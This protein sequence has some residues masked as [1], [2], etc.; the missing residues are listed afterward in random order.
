MA[1]KVYFDTEQLISEIRS[2]DPEL[3]EKV[4]IVANSEGTLTH[5]YVRY[6]DRTS[7]NLY[8]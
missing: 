3:F 5:V 8:I 1:C 2:I 7:N 6:V 4:S